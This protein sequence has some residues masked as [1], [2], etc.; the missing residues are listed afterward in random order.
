MP[1]HAVINQRRNALFE[2]WKA[3]S[4][5]Q[6]QVENIE[7][8]RRHAFLDDLD[9]EIETEKSGRRSLKN[10]IVVRRDGNPDANASVWVRAGYTGYQKAWLG[11]IKQVY[12]IDAKPADLAGYNIDHLLN[13]ARSP[14]GAGFIRIEAINGQVNQAWGRMFEKAASNPEF[15]ANQERYGRKLSWLIAA[16]LMGQMPPRGPSDQQGINRLVSFFNSQG[17]ASENPR[18]GLTNMLEFAYRFR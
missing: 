7:D 8:L 2:A 16:K 14:D 13:R 6:V 15:Y 1:L 11:F 18:E 17:M 9:L 10:A 4:F 3:N 5:Q 12:Q